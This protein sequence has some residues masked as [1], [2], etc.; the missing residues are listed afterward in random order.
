MKK[1]LYLLL[2]VVG[3]LPACLSA[4]V[5]Q[6]LNYQ[7]VARNGSGLLLINQPVSLRV[8]IHDSVAAGPALY[9]ETHT[10]QTNAFGTFGVVIGGGIVTHGTFTGI[11]WSRNDKFM[12]VEMD[13]NGGTNFTNMG[14]EQLITVPYSF[15][16]GSS[17]GDI[18]SITHDTTGIIN[19]L[20]RGNT[21]SAAKPIW[22]VG[23]NK[24][25]TATNNTI[26]TTDN[27]DLVL[28]R[29]GKES[30]RLTTGGA[31]LVTGDATG[32][33]P[34][35]GAGKR[36]MWIPA[37]GAFRVGSVSG[38]AWD[39]ANI[40][41]GSI[42]IG[43]DVLASGAN[44]IAM[45]NGLMATATNSTIVGAYNDTSAAVGVNKTEVLFQVGNG[46]NTARSSAF[47]VAR[48][49]RIV[50][51]S[52]VTQNISV[53]DTTVGSILGALTGPITINPQNKSFIRI[54]SGALP[55]TVPL[56]LAN[57][58]KIGQI[59][60]IEA[61]ASL[62]TSSNGIRINDAT[63]GASTSGNTSLNNGYVELQHTDMLTLIWDGTYWVEIARSDK[64]HQ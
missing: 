25:L 54:Y 9:T 17:K 18:V 47:T 49:G 51:P 11:D 45:G 35:A 37:K 33:T 20:T 15:Y 40:G 16:A 43:N 22:M 23:G 2:T 6:G 64:N 50:A 31:L 14:T 8:T 56:T 13:F 55:V 58:T 41:A 4:Q 46:S 44:A 59:L 53:Q 3:L 32:T 28:I 36:L 26:G 7:S 12:Q 57:G 63:Q 42:A 52:L 24:G 27:T 19:V 21:I 48:S 5:P 30:I 38:T 34:V 10:V 29:G 39:D 60:I 61:L 1:S 62:P